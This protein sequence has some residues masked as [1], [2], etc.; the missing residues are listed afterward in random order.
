MSNPRHEKDSLIFPQ[1]IY[2]HVCI[3]DKMQETSFC[4]LLSKVKDYVN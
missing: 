3:H 4:F 2:G 1:S